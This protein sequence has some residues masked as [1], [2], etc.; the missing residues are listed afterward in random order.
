M[1]YTQIPATDLRPSTICLGTADMG[2]KIERNDAFAMLDA[3]VEQGG[4]FLDTASVYANWLPIE[5]H[6]SEKTLGRWLKARNNRHRIIVGTKGAHPD[7]ATMHIPRMSDAEIL[8]DLNNSLKNLQ[9][10]YIDLYW[11]HRD[12]VRRPVGEIIE[13]LNR[14][15]AAGK[16]RYF[17]CSNWRVERI[18]AAQAYAAQHSLA[19]FVANQMLWNLAV[20]DFEMISDKTIVMMDETLWHYH[21]ETGLTAIPFS[22][23]ANGLFNKWANSQQ[24]RPGPQRIYHSP[25]NQ[26]RF[27][28]IQTL[29]TQ[30]ALSTSQV[31][32]GYLLSQPFTTIPIVGC[33]TMAQLQDSLSANDIQLTAEQLAYLEQG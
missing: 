33:Q 5:R 2:S 10:D 31:V 20:P 29:S 32:L 22:S 12:D 26:L 9:T 21:R 3:F 4:N 25:E 16:I 8:D 18:A 19:S 14:Q 1:N 11:L 6:S 23:Q 24:V 17:G 27:Q 13:T 28:R 7:L 30:T 15:V